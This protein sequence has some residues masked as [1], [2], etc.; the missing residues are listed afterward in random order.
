[1]ARA[2][3]RRRSPGLA[4]H[5]SRTRSVRRARPR[6]LGAPVDRTGVAL[7]A[8][9]LALAGLGWMITDERM[10]GMDAGPGSDPGALGFFL[11]VW[12]VGMA[13]MMFPSVWP[14][15]HAHDRSA[16][17]H[18]PNAGRTRPYRPLLHPQTARRPGRPG[19]ARVCGQLAAAGIARRLTHGT[20]A[21]SGSR[22]ATVP[23]R[24]HVCRRRER[25]SRAHSPGRHP[26]PK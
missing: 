9:L 17:E 7:V 11:T 18:A 1:M 22:R 3:S 2:D 6:L 25:L 5:I 10:A 20:S 4:D 24:S 16:G 15:Q 23:P 14:T 19:S 26:R 12:V 13:A 21:G 8:A